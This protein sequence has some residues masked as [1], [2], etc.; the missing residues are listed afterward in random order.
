VKTI[1]SAG[2][3]ILVSFIMNM[4]IEGCKTIKELN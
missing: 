1:L 2:T 3:D 4:I